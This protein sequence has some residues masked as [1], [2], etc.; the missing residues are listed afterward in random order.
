M[1]KIG[2]RKVRLSEIYILKV[3]AS[4]R[5]LRKVSFSETS[6]FEIYFIE[7]SMRQ[8]RT[9]KH[10][11]SKHGLPEIGVRKGTS[12]PANVTGMTSGKIRV[13]EVHLHES[14]TREVRARKVDADEYQG[15]FAVTADTPT[16]Y[17]HCSLH[18]G[19]PV[20]QPRQRLIDNWRRMRVWV[21]WVTGRPRSM[22]P[23]E[24]CQN[25]A[26]RGPICF[27]GPCDAFE[28]VYATNSDINIVVA[29]L[30][31]CPGEAFCYLAIAA[32]LHLTP[33]SNR[34]GQ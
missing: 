14:S 23:H 5:G 1:A 30:I 22:G 34:T 28:G 16:E 2:V 12:L 26:D 29:K 4:K 8:V 13:S 31:N 9:V 32:N 25:L 7:M 27:R 3:S 11:P 19:R 10:C 17:D 21:V 6:T 33:C 24:G 15:A 20:S 18:V